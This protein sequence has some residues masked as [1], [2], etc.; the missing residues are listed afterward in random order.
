MKVSVVI[1]T[2]NRKDDLIR[3]L[4]AYKNQTYPDKEI[5]VVDNCSTDG[6]KETIPS[7]FPD[8]KYIWLPENFDIRSIILGVYWSS[9]D[10]IWRCDSD[11]FPESNQAFEQVVEILQKYPEIDIIATEDVEVRRGYQ[12]WNWYP[13]KVNHENVP[14]D[15]YVSNGFCGTGAAIR[16]KVFET[17]GGFN[18]FGYEEYDFAARAIIAGFNIRYF[19]NIRTLHFA[20]TTERDVAYRWLCTCEQF[21]RF[22]WKFFPFFRAV[23]RTF[24][25]IGF[26]ILEG[27][28]RKLKPFV[29]LEGILLMLTTI[30]KTYRTER[31]VAPKDK[32]K[33]ITLGKSFFALQAKYFYEMFKVKFKKLFKK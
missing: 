13:L 8:V 4:E 23:G 6:T 30:F 19:P 1:V 29:I 11:S 31:M 15:G 32:L 2:R 16:R 9:G 14:P 20:S 24:L 18:G 3:T 26:Q 25:V 21:I 33:I 17:I 7:L 5:V 10:I 28:I 27:I 22:T 12:V